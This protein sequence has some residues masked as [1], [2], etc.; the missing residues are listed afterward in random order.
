MHK[1]DFD[2]TDEKKKALYMFLDYIKA[3]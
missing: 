3:L 1:I 2:L